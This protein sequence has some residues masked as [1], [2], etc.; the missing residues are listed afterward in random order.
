[1]EDVRFFQPGVEL[2]ARTHLDLDRDPYLADHQYKGSY[3]FP[4]VF[5]L[6]A[7]AQAVSYVLGRSELPALSI[8]EVRLQRPL[9]VLEAGQGAEAPGRELAAG[10]TTRTAVDEG[11]AHGFLVTS[12]GAE[13]LSTAPS[14][15]AV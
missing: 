15:I 3:L 4:T 5:G 11:F 14:L 9:L 1:M 7:M 8:Q 12:D 6:E 13:R 2:V 10:R